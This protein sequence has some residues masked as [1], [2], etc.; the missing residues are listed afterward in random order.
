MPLPLGYKYLQSSD[1]KR[2]NIDGEY[3]NVDGDLRCSSTQ[4]TLIDIADFIQSF[5]T[6]FTNTTIPVS[7]VIYICSI[8]KQQSILTL[9]SKYLYLSSA[10][11]IHIDSAVPCAFPN[12]PS[13]LLVEYAV[14]KFFAQND[15][16]SNE[17]LRNHPCLVFNSFMSI[18]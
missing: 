10:I 14:L 3:R 9:L 13:L 17:K 7:L 2:G 18:Y 16:Y 6:L 4:T 5:N 15:L 1:C 12:K 11:F 8:T